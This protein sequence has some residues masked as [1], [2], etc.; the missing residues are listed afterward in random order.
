MRPVLFMT[1]LGNDLRRAENLAALYDAYPGPKNF[2]SMY[3][4]N[5]VN[6]AMS[7]RYGTTVIDIFPTFPTGN[8][9]MIWHAIQGGKLIGLGQKGTYYKP[10]MAQNINWIVAAGRGGKEMFHQCTGVPEHRIL[11]LGMPR[12]DR[13]IGRKKG[14]GLTRLAKK[15]AY[16]Y[17][18]TFR[19]VK[20]DP[21]YPWIDWDYLD[22]VLTDDEILAVKPHP[23]GQQWVLD[24]YK[25]IMAVP[26]MEPSVNWLID[27]DV[28]ITDYSSIMFDGYLLGK[29]CVLFEKDRGYTE[30]RGM[31]MKYPGEYCS[32]YATNEQALVKLIRSAAEHGMEQV[33]REC[34]NYVADA[35]DGHSCERIIN[36]IEKVNG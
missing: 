17:V 31:Y 26:R 36:L 27:C 11:N 4:Q 25:H 2:I 15:R 28:V 23:Y 30:T 6:E 16:L 3:A 22:E 24:K 1:G 33:D 7:G 12:T 13:Y 9:I 20:T 8:T 19:N 29:P 21:G 32:R 10:E 5:A 18:P 35:C 14:D 34:V